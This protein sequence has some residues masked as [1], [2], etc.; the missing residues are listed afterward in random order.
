MGRRIAKGKSM[1]V[2]QIEMPLIVLIAMKM[3]SQILDLCPFTQ[4]INGLQDEDGCPGMELKPTS[5]KCI[6]KSTNDTLVYQSQTEGSTH[7]EKLFN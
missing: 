2:V 5:I 6:Q 1:T 3:V 7:G 4:I